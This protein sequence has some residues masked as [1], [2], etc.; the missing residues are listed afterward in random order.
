MHFQGVN[1]AL[2]KLEDRKGHHILADRTG[3]VAEILLA[4]K[5]DVN[6]K[7]STLNGENTPLHLAAAA[8]HKAVA[9]LL[10]ANGANV[11]AKNNNDQTPLFSAISSKNLEMAK[12]LIANKADVNAKDVSEKKKNMTSS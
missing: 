12:F 4:H 2:G 9:E 6:A 11:S 3:H 8:G 1:A 7:I 10:L 5:A